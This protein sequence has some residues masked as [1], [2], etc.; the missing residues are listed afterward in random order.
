MAVRKPSELLR[1]VSNI[2]VTSNGEITL[3]R[4]EQESDFRSSLYAPSFYL[5]LLARSVL[6]KLNSAKGDFESL[7]TPVDKSSLP[8]KA[9]ITDLSSSHPYIHLLLRSVVL[10]AFSLVYAIDEDR[11]ILSYISQKDIHRIKE[12]INYLTDF[13]S[14]DRK[15][16]NLIEP[17]RDTFISF[18]YLENQIDVILKERRL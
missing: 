18:G 9:M 7:D 5:S 13:M 17:L 4:I 8:G 2:S 10:E 1:F 14:T 11:E 12:N 16:R 6:D 3:N 15:Y